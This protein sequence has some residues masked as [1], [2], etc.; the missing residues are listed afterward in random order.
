TVASNSVLHIVTGNV[1]DLLFCRLTNY[2]TVAW[3]DGLVRGG[4][5]PGTFIYNFGL[6]DAQNDLTL[7][8]AYGGAG[9]VFNNAG[10]YRKSGGASTNT[11]TDGVTFNN[12]GL[13]EVLTGLLSLQGGGSFTGGTTTNA[14]GLIQLAAATYLINGTTTTT[15]VQLIGG[16][17]GN[18]TVLRGELTWVQGVLASAGFGAV[19]TVTVASNSVLHIVTGNVHDLLFCRLTN[20]GTVAWSDG[21]VRGGHNPGTF[22][23]NF[24][25]WDAQNDLTLNNAYAGAGTAFN[26]AGIYRKSGGAS[27]NTI[28]DG[29]TFNNTGTLDIKVGT[30]NLAGTYTLAGGTLSL[31]LNSLTDFGKLTLAGSA[32]LAGPLNA[33]LSGAFIPA[34][35]H[36]FKIVSCSGVSGTF[37]PLNVPAGTSVNYSNSG[38]F[39][40]VTNLAVQLLPPQLAGANFNFSFPTANGQNYTVQCNDDLNTT[41]WVLHTNFIGDGLPA[42]IFVPPAGVPQRYFRVWGQ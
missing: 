2:G 34:V 27:T 17:L 19:V 8:N 42:Q 40:I 35:G 20:Y 13:L 3:S 18:G 21:L 16:T 9:T 7:N 23:Y 15:N 39:L 29:V 41:N 37:S 10:I 5:N 30:V 11:I 28:T 38:V 31:R 4:H 14:G 12:N 26:N 24:G 1:H 22:I 6:W 25:L 36:Q 33:S 32:A